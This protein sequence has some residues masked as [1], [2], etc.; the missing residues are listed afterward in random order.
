MSKREF[1]R[2]NVKLHATLIT[3][4]YAEDDAN[5]RKLRFDAR[6]ILE[7]FSDYEFGSFEMNDIHL[8]ICKSKDEDGYYKLTTNIKI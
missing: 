8:A 2:D 4:K 5:K 7:Q 1:D 3:T 6:K